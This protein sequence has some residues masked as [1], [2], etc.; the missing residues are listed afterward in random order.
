MKNETHTND[1]KAVK[2]VKEGI[3]FDEKEV[4]IQRLYHLMVKKFS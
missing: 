1:E 2:I 3:K 4:N